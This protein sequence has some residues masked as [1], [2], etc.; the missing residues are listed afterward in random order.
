MSRRAEHHE[1]VLHPGFGVELGIH[2]LAL[3]QAE[4]DLVM[5]QALGDGRGVAHLQMHPALGVGLEE[6]R[7]DQ[8]QQVVADGQR[9]AHAQ[10][11]QAL[12][13]A[14]AALELG[15]AVEQLHRVRQQQAALLVEAQTLAMAVEERLCAVPFQFGKRRARRRLRQREALGGAGDVLGPS[16]RD[17]DLD[18]TEGESHIDEVD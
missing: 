17:E 15:G 2:H 3:D 13:A 6:I 12:L 18:L 7:H 5:Q 11:T 1:F 10:R 16:H 9:R 14:H 8:R 4:V